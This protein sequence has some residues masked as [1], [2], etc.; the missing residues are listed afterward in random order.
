MRC[1]RTKPNITV[2]SA[3]IRQN[4]FHYTSLYTRGG[5]REVTSEPPNVL[6][7]ME[8]PKCKKKMVIS[9]YI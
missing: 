9:I 8:E 1:S 2:I 4:K 5:Q 7:N 6:I 3:I